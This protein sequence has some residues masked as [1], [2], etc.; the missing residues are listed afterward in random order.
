MDDNNKN[1][2][3]KPI[4]TTVG[5][6]GEGARYTGKGPYQAAKKAANALFKQAGMTTGQMKLELRE[7]TRGSPKKIFA[8]K[9]ER[10]EKPKSQQRSIN[11]AT[12]VNK[13]EV[14][15]QS[16]SRGGGNDNQEE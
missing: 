9:A 3:F 7:I 2:T 1:R 16:Q 6:I 10:V 11:G 4:Q 14:R 8:Y 13:F 5:T 15:L 12:F